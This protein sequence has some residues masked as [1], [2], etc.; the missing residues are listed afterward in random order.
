MTDLLENKSELALFSNK[1]ASDNSD[2]E[3]WSFEHE[4]LSSDQDSPEPDSLKSL[5]QNCR[6]TYTLQE[7]REANSDAYRTIPSELSRFLLKIHRNKSLHNY[8]N[9]YNQ[10]LCPLE[11][12]KKL[13][14]KAEAFSDEKLVE[15][16]K[17]I[18]S[19]V[20]EHNQEKIKDKVRRIPFTSASWSLIV[21]M[22]HQVTIDCVFLMET[23]SE[24]IL[25]LNEIQPTFLQQYKAT[26]LKEFQVP[27]QFTEHELS[28]ES[29][30]DKAKR[31]TL[32][33]WKITA[34]LYQQNHYQSEE[35]TRDFL[36]PLLKAIGPEHLINLDVI[37]EIWPLIKDC[38][39]VPRQE[40]MLHQIESISQDDRFPR[41][42]RFLLM[43]LLEA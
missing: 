26:L 14:S 12:R 15:D 13:F 28:L 42:L 41:R 7:L 18:L 25:V 10:W 39:P 8:L 2:S 4:S 5:S 35:F 32:A 38:L 22:V 16:L 31:W 24:I 37:I 34:Y 1:S 33:N 36:D 17:T 43:D 11:Q 30:T 6:R 20:S 9:P 23:L 29:A 3:S 40:S 27:S 21:P 19:K